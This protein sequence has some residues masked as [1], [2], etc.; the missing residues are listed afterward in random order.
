MILVVLMPWVID[1]KT[2]LCKYSSSFT[3]LKLF[4][5]VGLADAVVSCFQNKTLFERYDRE[6]VS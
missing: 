1:E 2:F 6:D 5:C 4:M 3:W